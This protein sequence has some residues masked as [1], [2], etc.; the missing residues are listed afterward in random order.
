MNKKLDIPTTTNREETARLEK[1]AAGAT[2]AL[3]LFLVPSLRKNKTIQTTTNNKQQT[4]NNEQRT[5]IIIIKKLESRRK[6]ELSFQKGKRESE[7][8]GKPV[9]GGGNHTTGQ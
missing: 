5:I 8:G 6:E 4:T 7:K 2:K 1:K 3:S 9:F